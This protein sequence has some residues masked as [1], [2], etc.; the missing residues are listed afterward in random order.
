[1]TGR[2]PGV[3]NVWQKSFTETGSSLR[4]NLQIAPPRRSF[5]VE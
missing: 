3:A 1:M 2:M 4:R 5:A